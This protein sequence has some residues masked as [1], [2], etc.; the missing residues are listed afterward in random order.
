MERV[1]D[2]IAGNPGCTVKEIMDARVEH[3]YSCDS[4]ARSC[5]PRNLLSIEKGVRGEMSGG[6]WRFWIEEAS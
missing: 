1:R 2:F 4:T 3:H 5:I 6:K